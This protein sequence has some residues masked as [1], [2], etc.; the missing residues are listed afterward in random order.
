MPIIMKPVL[1]EEILPGEAQIVRGRAADRLNLAE[2]PVDSLPDNGCGAIDHRDR[3]IQMVGMHEVQIRRGGIDVGHNGQRHV[4]EPD[5][6]SGDMPV[7]VAR[8]VTSCVEP[9]GVVFWVLRF[10]SRSVRC[11]IFQ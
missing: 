5:I 9:T 3:A 11:T 10:A 2:R 1:G 4:V 8:S 6:L 7:R